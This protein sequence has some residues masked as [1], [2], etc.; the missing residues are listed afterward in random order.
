MKQVGITG[1]IGSGKTTV[2]R[3]FQVL[4]IPVFNADTEARKLQENDI[5]LIAEMRKILGDECFATDGRL[6]RKTTAS[7]VFQKP[8]LLAELNSIVHPAVARAFNN[9]KLQQAA[10]FVL[11]EAAIMIESGSHRDLDALIVVTAPEE[12]RINRVMKRDNTTHAQVME[13]INRQM[14]EA[15]RLDHADFVIVNDDQT[16]IIPQ[17]LDIYHKLSG[18]ESA[19]HIANSPT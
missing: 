2:S 12:V 18:N 4:G 7:K 16:L 15:E 9:W 5:E 17:I 6:D 19:P 3:I 10:P 8:E 13:R 1:G 11:R 14:P